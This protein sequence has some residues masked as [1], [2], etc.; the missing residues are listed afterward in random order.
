MIDVSCLVNGRSLSLGSARTG[1][2][3][4]FCTGGQRSGGHIVAQGLK[5]VVA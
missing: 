3:D 1:G 5:S 2:M 4:R